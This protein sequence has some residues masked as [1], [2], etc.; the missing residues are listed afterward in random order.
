MTAIKKLPKILGAPWE[1]DYSDPRIAERLRAS[2]TMG[3]MVLAERP[4]GWRVEWHVP[5][6]VGH[7]TIG[8]AK[9]PVE[10]VTK[11]I[12]TMDGLLGLAKTT[13]SAG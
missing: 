6:T 5:F 13:A 8:A 10:A 12:E 1:R 3:R 2:T 9:D 4:H 11:A 7:V